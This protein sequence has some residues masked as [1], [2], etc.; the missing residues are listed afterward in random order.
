M[1]PEDKKDIETG[2]YDE[3]GKTSSSSV[4]GTETTI[5]GNI[6]STGELRV[7][8]RIEGDIRCRV[9]IVDINACVKGTIQADLLKVY[10]SINGCLY[11]KSVFLASSAKVVGNITHEQIEIQPGAFLEGHCRHLDDPIPAEQGPSDLM[12]TDARQLKE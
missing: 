7:N 11:A 3:N 9:L 12:L 5:T 8:G 6:I 1:F 4:I 10:G 2:I